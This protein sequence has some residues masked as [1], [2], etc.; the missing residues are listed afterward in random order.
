MAHQLSID[1]SLF[2]YAQGKRDLW[3][4]HPMAELL[5]TLSDPAEYK[6]ATHKSEEEYRSH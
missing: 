3:Y 6:I 4:M 5:Y 1:G 2:D